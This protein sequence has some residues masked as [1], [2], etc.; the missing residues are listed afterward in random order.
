M[1]KPAARS[2][3]SEGSAHAGA[4]VVALQLRRDFEGHAKWLR[5]QYGRA[6]R[7]RRRSS[8]HDRAPGRM[9]RQ[10][11]VSLRFEKLDGM[12]AGG[13][14]SCQ[15]RSLYGR[16]APQEPSAVIGGI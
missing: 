3:V 4:Q 14:G 2:E 12:S 5:L 8:L 13:E 1:V 10:Q 15:Y 7:R 9:S 16:F 11:N 6:L